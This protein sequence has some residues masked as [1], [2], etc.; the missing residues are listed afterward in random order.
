VA[1][2]SIFLHVRRPRLGQHFLVDAR[3]RQ[4]IAAAVDL[5]PD[6]LVVEIGPGRGAMTELLAE[7][8]RSVVAVE[9]DGMLA[10]QL[11]KKLGIESP[12]EVLRAD[13]LSVDLAELCRR[14]GTERCFVF[15]NLPYYITSPIIHRLFLFHDRLRAVA[16]LVQHEVAER[17]VAGP[18][19]RAYGYLSVFT[20]LFSYPRILLGVPPGAFAPPP[21]IQS[22]LVEFRMRETA[23][24]KS[25]LSMGEEA[26][27]LE[28]V[29]RCFAQKRKN[30]PNNLAGFHSGGRVEL[31]L[32]RLSLARSARAEQLTLEE[33]L[34]LYRRLARLTDG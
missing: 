28:F 2:W 7:R 16:L 10:E 26:G 18:G 30:L 12:I 1:R 17:L 4:R 31:E 25:I 13:I 34:Q 15:G 8:A 27:F 9:L 24:T 29:K 32:D 33:L 14:H 3:Y 5:R 23:G 22:T 6:D 20:Q 21:K 19:T 11:Q